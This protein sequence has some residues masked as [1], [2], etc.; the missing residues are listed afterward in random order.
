VAALDTTGA[1]DVF[2]GV[3]AAAWAMGQALPDAIATAQHAAAISV[4]REGCFGSF[5]S[6]QE[7]KNVLF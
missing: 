4:G 3:L 2:C 6:K 5:P 1:G 7:I